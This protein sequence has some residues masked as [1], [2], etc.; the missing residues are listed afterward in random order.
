MDRHFT[1]ELNKL[2]ASDAH[3][4]AFIFSEIG[5]IMAEASGFRFYDGDHVQL[6]FK[7]LLTPNSW[8]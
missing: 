6:A 5:F 2:L 8:L 7:M 4:E 1:S 3:D